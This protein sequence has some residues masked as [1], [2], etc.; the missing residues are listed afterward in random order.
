MK[1]IKKQFVIIAVLLALTA[2]LWPAKVTS[3]EADDT[4]TISSSVKLVRNVWGASGGEKVDVVFS[5]SDSALGWTWSR[6]NPQ[7]YRDV[8]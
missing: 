7:P 6:L 4:M 1:Y 8:S 2:T 3:I 5:R